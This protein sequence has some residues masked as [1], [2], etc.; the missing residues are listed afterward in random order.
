MLSPPIFF[1]VVFTFFQNKKYPQQHFTFIIFSLFCCR[2]VVPGLTNLTSCRFALLIL[3]G[4]VCCAPWWPPG[5]PLPS[6]VGGLLTI[7]LVPSFTATGWVMGLAPRNFRF[8]YYRTAV[9]KLALSLKMCL[10]L[11]F[12]LL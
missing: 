9:F 2:A 5:T 4:L 8:F 11:I 6:V 7:I 10:N 12:Y 3:Y 1:L